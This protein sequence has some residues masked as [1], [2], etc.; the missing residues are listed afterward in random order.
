MQDR[1]EIV[2]PNK[3]LHLTAATVPSAFTH[4]FVYG[5]IAAGPA[6][7]GMRVALLPIL[8]WLCAPP[9]YAGQTEPPVKYELRLIH[10]FDGK[11]PE[12]IFAIGDS[13][14]RT[15]ES[16]KTFLGTLPAGS[17]IRWA[18][19]GERFGNEPLL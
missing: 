18:P 10:V 12:Y 7:L 11:Q 13:G 6:D 1:A 17:E 16:L 3:P 4:A 14:F 5:K 8:L 15:V 19:G 9:A 2:T